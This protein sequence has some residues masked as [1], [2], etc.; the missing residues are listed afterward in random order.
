MK[1]FLKRVAAAAM[2]AAATLSAQAQQY[3]DHP[4]TIVVPYSPGGVTD[5]IG[6]LLGEEMG[7]QMGQAVVVENKAGAGGNIGNAFVAGSKPDGYTLLMMID[8]GTIAPALYP[9]LSYDPIKSFVPITMLATGAHLI[10]AQ[11]SFGP[12]KLQQLIAAA[13]A[14]PNTIF[15]ASSGTG[16]SQHLGMERLKTATG[17]QIQHVPYKGGGQAINALVAGQVPLGM[18]GIAP[19]LPHLRAGT[20]KALAITSARRSPLLP[21]VPTVSESGVPGFESFNWFAL[22]APAGTP[23]AITQRLHD[24]A[25]KAMRAPG[26]A[27]RFAA[28]GVEV[29]LSDKPA[30]LTRFMREDIVKWPAIVK[31]NNIRVD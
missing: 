18:I 20:L 9:R 23:A 19:A 24:E 25:V 27:E 21:E 14:K 26:M 13:K 22:L 29:T 12:N 3:P 1:T 17:M 4:I 7:K 15:F 2:L 16:T 8:A 30:D 5:V 31:A 10:V 11:P 28:L 6:R